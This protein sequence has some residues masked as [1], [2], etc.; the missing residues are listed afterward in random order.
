[1][2]KPVALGVRIIPFKDTP[3]STIQLASPGTQAGSS[4]APGAYGEPI[5]NILAYAINSSKK[6]ETEI[7]RGQ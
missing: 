1:M 4:V 7:T 3:T 6:K 5:A 2:E